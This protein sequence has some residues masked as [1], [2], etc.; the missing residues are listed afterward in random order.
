MR[1]S[2]SL[3]D[4][5]PLF[6]RKVKETTF[7]HLGKPR[8]PLFFSAKYH[9]IE[10]GAMTNLFNIIYTSSALFPFILPFV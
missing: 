9:A 5:V 3:K 1:S 7:H 6:M 10:V 8:N 2:I 4:Q